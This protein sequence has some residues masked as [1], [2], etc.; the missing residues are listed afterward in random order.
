MQVQLTRLALSVFG[1]H[2][3]ISV[4]DKRNSRKVVTKV[5]EDVSLLSGA[6]SQL[7]IRILILFDLFEVSRTER[8]RASF[9]WPELSVCFITG[10]LIRFQPIRRNQSTCGH[11]RP[12]PYC[13][14]CGAA[15]R[16]FQWSQPI[17]DD[18]IQ[19][20]NDERAGLRHRMASAL[21]RPFRVLYRRARYRPGERLH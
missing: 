9:L 18:E 4:T 10:A 20:M 2:M 12:T 11:C 15:S 13:G 16:R 19:Q 8:S 5:S 21:A 7:T 1:A 3:I 14:G 17:C 6:R